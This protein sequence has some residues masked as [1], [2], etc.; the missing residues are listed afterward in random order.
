MHRNSFKSFSS[1]HTQSFTTANTSR[2]FELDEWNGSY[3]SFKQIDKFDLIPNAVEALTGFEAQV[4]NPPPIDLD[5]LKY[6][7]ASNLYQTNEE[8]NLRVK[9]NLSKVIKR[10]ELGSKPK[11][12]RQFSS[13]GKEKKSI[14]QGEEWALKFKMINAD[15]RLIKSVLLAHNFEQTEGHDWNILWTNTI[16]KPYLYTGLNEHQKVNHFPSSY[17]ITRK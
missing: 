9:E 5:E 8:R 13:R 10:K 17:E 14:Y 1:K 7:S 3:C 15:S 16:G 2:P 6:S 11:K 4:Q 12:L